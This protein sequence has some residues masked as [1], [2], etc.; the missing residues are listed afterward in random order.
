MELGYPQ[1]YAEANRVARD[2]DLSYLRELG[3]FIKALGVITSCAERNK[4]HKDKII[5][6]K[7]LSTVGL[8]IGGSFLLFRGA[9]MA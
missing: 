1:L 6:G 4:K 2:M 9:P 3:P 8:N 5:N 7:E